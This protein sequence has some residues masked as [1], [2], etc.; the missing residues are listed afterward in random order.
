MPEKGAIVRWGQSLEAS[1]CKTMDTIKSQVTRSDGL[2]ALSYLAKVLAV[3]LKVLAARS[4]E[5]CQEIVNRS[6]PHN[7]TMPSPRF[8]DFWNTRTTMQLQFRRAH[9]LASFS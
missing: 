9:S 1:C 4:T 6:T 3:Q 8:F 7:V 2:L 5:W